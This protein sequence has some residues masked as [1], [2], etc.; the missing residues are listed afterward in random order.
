MC[1]EV[2]LSFNGRLY[3]K[4]QSISLTTSSYLD[5]AAWYYGSKAPPLPLPYMKAKIV[6]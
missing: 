2:D 5:T 6:L 4:L 1:T 3:I